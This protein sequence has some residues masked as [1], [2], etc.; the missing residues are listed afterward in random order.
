MEAGHHVDGAVGG[1][2][3]EALAAAAAG[4]SVRLFH[5]VRTLR[6]LE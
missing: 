4:S 6:C 1:D 2:G 3:I 5:R